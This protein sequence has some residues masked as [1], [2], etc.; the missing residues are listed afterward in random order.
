MKN[1]IQPGDSLTFTA[2]AGGVLSGN[3]YLIGRCFGIAAGDAADAAPFVLKTE[4]V[5]EVA[6]VSAQAWTAGAAIYWDNTAKLFT[7]VVSTNWFVG[8]AT[9]AAANPTAVG[10]VR[11]NGSMR[12]AAEA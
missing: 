12:I 7:T 2:P 6:K 11:L 10:R 1:Y 9:E 8:V 3:A 5:F 4:G